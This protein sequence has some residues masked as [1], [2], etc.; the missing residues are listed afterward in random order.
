MGKASPAPLGQALH[1]PTIWGHAKRGTGLINNELYIGR[2]I[3]NRLHYVRN[4]ETGKRGVADQ[5]PRRTGSSRSSPSSASSTTISGRRSRTARGKSRS[6][7]PP[8]SRTAAMSAAWWTV[9]VNWKRARTSSPNSSLPCPP[10]SRT[11]TPTSRTST[12]ARWRGLPARWTI[13]RTATRRLPPF[14]GLIERIVLTPGEKW[15]AMDAVLHGDLGTILECAGN[16][17][18]ST[19]T[20]ISMLEMSVSLVAREDLKLRPS[21]YED[22]SVAPDSFY[23]PIASPFGMTIFVSCESSPSGR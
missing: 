3:W 10:T 20:D 1:R 9:Y 19:K 17:R 14:R 21:G 18:G 16:G 2:L 4:P 15:A 23:Q 22:G 8:S 7:T 6:N 11:S 5:P 13:R 12:G